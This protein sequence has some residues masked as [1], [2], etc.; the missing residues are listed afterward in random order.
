MTHQR[1]KKLIQ[2]SYD[3]NENRNEDDFKKATPPPFP[4]VFAALQIE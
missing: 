2:L 1:Q 3:H 4:H